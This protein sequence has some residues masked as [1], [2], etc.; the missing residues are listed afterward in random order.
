[1]SYRANFIAGLR[2]DP[3]LSVSDW[4]DGHRMLSQTASTEP[5]RW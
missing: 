1:M 4:A 2:P 5:G 3:L